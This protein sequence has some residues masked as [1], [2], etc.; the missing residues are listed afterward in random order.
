[1]DQN[2]HMRKF[3][4]Q[5]PQGVWK[6]KLRCSCG[7]SFRK[8]LW[9]NNANGTK[10]YGYECYRQKRNVSAAFLK[11]NHLDTETVCQTKSIPAWQLDLMAKKVFSYVWK[12]QK[13]AVLLAC[14]MLE[15]CNYQEQSHENA[16]TDSLLKRKETLEKKL[17]G[18]REM[19][20][21]GDITRE[22]F[23][24]DKRKIEEECEKLEIQLHDLEQS[25]PCLLYTS[26]SPRDR[27]KSRMPSSA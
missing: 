17:E 13:D 1:M 12:D 7:S 20:A 27:Q 16:V 21:L 9:H 24:T 23:L 5:E 11:R 3:G 25:D 6:Q 22:E 19:R 2:G 18:L 14:K 10:T 8:Y 15:E 26:P 4:S